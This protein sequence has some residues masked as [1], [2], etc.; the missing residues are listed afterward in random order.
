MTLRRRYQLLAKRSRAAS[1]TSLP[2]GHQAA[3]H[4]QGHEGHLKGDVA[5]DHVEQPRLENRR[6]QP[7]QPEG[8]HQGRGQDD[9]RDDHRDVE[10]HVQ[11]AAGALAARG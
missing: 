6:N 11:N 10:M 8:H 4:H 3:A 7:Q 2:D 1:S 9:V 5:D